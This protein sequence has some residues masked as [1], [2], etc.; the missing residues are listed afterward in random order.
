M[1]KTITVTVLVLALSVGSLKA[2]TLETFPQAYGETTHLLEMGVKD[3]PLHLSVIK[4]DL[5]TVQKLIEYGADVNEKWKGKTPAILAARHNQ[6]EI[7]KYLIAEGANLKLRCDNG[8][9][10]AYHAKHSGAK[11]T[12]LLIEQTLAKK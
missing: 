9:N 4:G 12:A 3:N 11:D 10:A 8:H 2:L 6:V 7:L 5:E 1:Q